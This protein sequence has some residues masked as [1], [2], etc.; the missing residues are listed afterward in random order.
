[1]EK[2]RIIVGGYIGSY[3]ISGATWDYIQYP[4]GFHLL[5]HDV[6][7]IE[8]TYGFYWHYTEGD[9][10][11][12]ISP[13]LRH[14]NETM[15]YFGL[16]DRWAYRD[17]M[18]GKCFGMPIAKVMEICNTADV[19]ISV[20]NSTFMR[21]EYH[22]IPK[23]VLIDTDPM[24]TQ[25]QD[26][27]K[28]NGSQ[29]AVK[30]SFSSFNYL[31]TFGENIHSESCRIPTYGLKW[32]TTRQPICLPYWKKSESPTAH[33]FTTIMNWSERE[34]LLFENEEWG[35]KDIE[36]NRYV[37][38]PQEFDKVTFSIVVSQSI[39]KK[40]NFDYPN[41]I[42]AGWH[43]LRNYDYIKSLSDYQN[44]IAHSLG[45]FSVAKQTYVAAKSG[46]FSCRSA[47]YL[48]SARPVIVQDTEWSKYIPSGE[49]LFAFHNMDDILY[50]LESVL[51]NPEHHSL[52][53]AEIASEFFD[54][55][56]VL[57]RML[58]DIH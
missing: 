6:Y 28:Y 49:G 4:L 42:N 46:W 9:A 30:E 45:E 11:D 51:S 43:I 16:E 35:Q 47:C 31:F 29:Q 38:L 27:K 40:K 36:F 17:T 33:G 12:D 19:F 32:Y 7:Y 1:V 26:L 15:K 41:I 55:N 3:C 14:F 53:A 10:W 5:G 13:I 21:D 44:F 34:K 58:N 56:K 37:H 2:L 57:M 50:A 52:K 39:E 18:T 54:S 20:S 25:I 8:D 22:Q 48:A 23:R 24:F